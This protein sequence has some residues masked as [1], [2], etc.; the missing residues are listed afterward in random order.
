MRPC[1]RKHLFASTHGKGGER[2]R[3]GSLFAPSFQ[4]KSPTARKNVEQQPRVACVTQRPCGRHVCGVSVRNPSPLSE[5]RMHGEH[6]CMAAGNASA[7]LT[8]A[9]YNI[10]ES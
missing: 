9:S 10:I 4:A 2:A 1:A 5:S 8:V 7:S 3:E 6:I